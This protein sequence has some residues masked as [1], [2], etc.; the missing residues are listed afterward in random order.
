MPFLI[1]NKSILTYLY[2]L[3]KCANEQTTIQLEAT[4]RISERTA[5]HRES[6]NLFTQNVLVSSRKS[7]ELREG[8]TVCLNTAAEKQ[9]GGYLTWAVSD[10]AAELW[11]E[12][13]TVLS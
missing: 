4:E 12:H 13:F 10:Q 2:K 1:R 11:R 9:A 7:L 5:N 8:R 6:K 3:N